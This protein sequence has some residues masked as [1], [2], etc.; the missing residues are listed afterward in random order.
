M[1]RLGHGKS[2]MRCLTLHMRP[3][4]PFRLGMNWVIGTR[5]FLGT[6]SMIWGCLPRF[7]KRWLG[8]GNPLIPKL[9]V[10]SFVPLNL[11]TDSNLLQKLYFPG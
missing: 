2:P 5:D 7:A 11:L 4:G 3:K 9:S 1:N 8:V 6:L 10:W